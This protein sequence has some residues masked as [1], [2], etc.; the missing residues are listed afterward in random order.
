MIVADP[1]VHVRLPDVFSVL[2]SITPLDVI[3]R[4][5]QVDPATEI[6]VID[7]RGIEKRELVECGLLL[8]NSGRTV[9]VCDTTR[10]PVDLIIQVHNCTVE[11]KKQGK[12]VRT[13]LLFIEEAIEAVTDLPDL[14]KLV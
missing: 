11:A 10:L 14:E 6:A 1:G 12:A 3:S 4:K 8:R 9:V 13:E 7:I 2:A 5:G